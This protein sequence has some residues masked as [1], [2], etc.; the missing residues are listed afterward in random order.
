[1]GK[2][3]EGVWLEGIKDPELGHMVTPNYMVRL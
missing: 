1:M 2:E 3:H